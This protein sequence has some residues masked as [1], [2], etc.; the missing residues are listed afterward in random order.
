MAAW[1]ESVK[2]D[3]PQW[4]VLKDLDPQGDMSQ[5]YLPQGDGSYLAQGYAPT[6]FTQSFVAK[7]DVTGIT[8]F[9]L[10]LLPD[11][12]CRAA[13]RA[14]R[15][16][17]PA[18]SPNLPS[19]PARSTIR[20]KRR[21]QICRGHQRL[22]SAG[23]SARSDLRRQDDHQAHHRPGEVRH[24]RQPQHRLGNRRRPGPAQRRAQGRLP[25]R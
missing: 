24:R 3:Q 20:R 25:L 13:A 22:R 10:E 12:I 19:M 23:T 8:A 11:L 4:T 14:A 17:A 18:H 9:R 1:E 15:S 6:K 5:R 21:D 16:M 2:D 7:T